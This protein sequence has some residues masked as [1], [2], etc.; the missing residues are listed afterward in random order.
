VLILTPAVAHAY[1][2]TATMAAVTAATYR[3]PAPAGAD[4]THSC[5]PN[6]RNYTLNITGYAHVS[7]ATSYRL[8]I[9]APDGST[10]SPH[11]FTGGTTTLTKTSA[12]R[13]TYTFTL[14][15]LV[16]SWTGT[17]YTGSNSC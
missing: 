9:T 8:V 2:T 6:G 12:R 13:G 16:G 14:Q 7:K 17:A 1:F 5:S 10:S 4:W 3:I 15:A 11:D